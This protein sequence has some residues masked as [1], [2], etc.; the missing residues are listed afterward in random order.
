MAPV[1]IAL[2]WRPPLAAFAP[3]SAEP[4]ALLLGPVGGD[5]RWSLLMARPDDVFE[6]SGAGALAS[7]P[8]LNP[9]AGTTPPLPFTGG[10]AGLACYELGASLERVPRLLA[11]AAKAGIIIREGGQGW[12][13]NPR[14]RLLT[15]RHASRAGRVHEQCPDRHA[16][17]GRC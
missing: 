1:A 5:D 10:Y 2:P 9:A 8:P 16:G 4:Y 17:S 7:L 14:R 13:H 15:R 11:K 12:H 6:A 3:L